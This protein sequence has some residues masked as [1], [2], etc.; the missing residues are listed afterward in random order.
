MFNSVERTEFLYHSWRPLEIGDKTKEWNKALP[1]PMLYAL[2]D[3]SHMYSCQANLD[4]V[5]LD[6]QNLI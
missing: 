4:L 5:Y 1:F 3:G 6:P 2:P